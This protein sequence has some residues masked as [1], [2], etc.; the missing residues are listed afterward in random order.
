[1]RRT[2][3]CC[4]RVQGSEPVAERLRDMVWRDRVAGLEV[5][6]RARDA[7]HAVVSASRE[8]HAPVS[9]QQQVPRPAIEQR[10]ATRKAPVHPAVADGG[11]AYEAS[12]LALAGDDDTLPYG[13]A[14][15]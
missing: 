1:M 13:D 10:V 7:Q 15:V 12:M 3:S 9:V 11:R 8:C 14:A 4:E 6:N 5:R 2:R